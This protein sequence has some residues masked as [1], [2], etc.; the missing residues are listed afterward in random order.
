MTKQ[1]YEEALADVKKLKEVAEDNA[2][3]ALIEAVAPRIK[4]LIEAELLREAE[5]GLKNPADS[6]LLLD[7]EAD[8]QYGVPSDEAETSIGAAARDALGDTMPDVT[9][10]ISMP[11]EEGKVTLDLD[12]LAVEPTGAADEYM[13]SNESRRFMEPFA[14]KIN[15][16]SMKKFE[17]QLLDVRQRYKAA[18]S[19]SKN[20][21]RTKTYGKLVSELRADVENLYKYLQES[22]GNHTDKPLYENVLEKF[23]ENLN[24]L[25]ESNMKNRKSLTEAELSFTIKNLPDEVEDVLDDVEIEL[26]SGDGGEDEDEGEEELDLEEPEEGEEEDKEAPE[27]E[28]AEEGDEEAEDLGADLGLGDEAE[29]EEKKEGKTMESR[30]LSDNTIV[31]ID[32]GMLRREISRM[33]ALREAAD[34]VQDWGH[35]A[36]EVSDEFEDEDLGDPFLDV[37][38][39]TEGVDEDD[40]MEGVEE[41]DEM[42]MEGVEEADEVDELDELDQTMQGMQKQG[43]YGEVDEVDEMDMEGVEEV[44]QAADKSQYGGAR[45]DENEQTNKQNRQVESIRRRLDAEKR[46]QVEA[47]TKAQ[48]AKKKHAEAAK[49]TKQNQV[50]AQKKQAAA[51]QAA[52][53]KQVKEAQKQK[54]QAQQK[55]REAQKQAKQAKQMKEAYVYFATKFNES[56]QRTSR[57]QSM[58]AEVRGNG[59]NLNGS[60]R[61]AEGSDNLRKKLA[62]T[63]LFNM[64]LLYTNKLLQNE[65]LTKRQKADIIEK[66]DEATT[67]R[68]VK[69][70]YESLVKTLS[71]K[72]KT[73]S[74]GANRVLG[75]SS[76]PTRAA[77]TVLNEGFEADRW[78]KLAGIK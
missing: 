33:K 72:G 64:K 36:G 20:L 19:A 45:G 43:A 78:A 73:L 63:N 50:E 28:E 18:T 13:V 27:G 62:E 31:E 40:N 30:R 75:S 39:T 74:E 11:D 15:E 29:G 6:D 49:K 25:T 9:N 21:Q 38:V 77:S 54:A 41:A 65:A 55:Q 24:Q 60:S 7:D 35:G 71:G 53:K 68:E 3:K 44:D 42:D 5:V 8:M 32:E 67:D 47:K 59:A 57:L 58:L 2:K 52:Q 70:V 76:A 26:G 17:D 56:V 48:M 10:A 16:A 12:A 37:D 61:L 34:D 51:K 1:L 14:K 66:L 46:L 22:V 23:Y 4:D 69:L